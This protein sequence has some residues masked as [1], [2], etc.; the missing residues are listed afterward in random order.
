MWKFEQREM[1]RN[2]ELHVS[3]INSSLSLE[4]Y[5]FCEGKFS[6]GGTENNVPDKKDEMYH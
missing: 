5:V 3:D 2:N 4:L 1:I 6:K